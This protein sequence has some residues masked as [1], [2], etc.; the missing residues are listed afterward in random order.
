M[1]IHP[2]TK[3]VVVAFAHL[4]A[5]T[6]RPSLALS[7]SFSANADPVVASARASPAIPR[8]ERK[9]AQKSRS[10]RRRKAPI[11]RGQK[12]TLRELWP[13]YG[14]LTDFNARYANT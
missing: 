4:F 3:S 6:R 8:H 5:P 2:C 14:L 13:K 9:R 10:F 7:L 12:R 1:V 11:T